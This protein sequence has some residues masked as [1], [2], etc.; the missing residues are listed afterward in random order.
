[1]EAHPTSSSPTKA[2]P[3]QQRPDMEMP[4]DEPDGEQQPL[5]AVS[6]KKT[7]RRACT[8]QNTYNTRNNTRKEPIEA[9][10]ENNGSK[11]NKENNSPTKAHGEKKENDAP[12]QPT[13]APILTP[14]HH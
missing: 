6:R 11:E 9:Y 10:S 5:S 12:P 2:R 3:L 1:M 13:A 4:V 14:S 8:P 7:K